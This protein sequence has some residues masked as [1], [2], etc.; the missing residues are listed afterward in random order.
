MSTDRNRLARLSE[1]IRGIPDE[2]VALQLDLLPLC[3]DDAPGAREKD[4]AR[5]ADVA[6]RLHSLIGEL[7]QIVEQIDDLRVSDAAASDAPP[8]ATGT[9]KHASP[10]EGRSVDG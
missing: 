3:R 4:R 8:L 10:P 9:R 6:S 7:A 2:L 1:G 5:I